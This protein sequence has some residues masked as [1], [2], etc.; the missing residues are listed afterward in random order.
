MCLLLNKTK[1][2]SQNFTS[3]DGTCTS[4][5]DKRKH[6]Y[7]CYCK[8]FVILLYVHKLYQATTCNHQK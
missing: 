3:D 4:N 8:Y 1:M 2:A 5:Y 6:V 7:R